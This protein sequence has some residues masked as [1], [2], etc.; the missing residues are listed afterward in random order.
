[1]PVG[2][3]DYISPEILCCSAQDFQVPNVKS[4]QKNSHYGP[5]CD[6]WSLGVVGY[7]LL[8]GVTPFA[9]DSL[10]E[11]Y[12]KIVNHEVKF[13][14]IYLCIIDLLNFFYFFF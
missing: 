6:F 5:E 1:M 12:N 2:T 3:P 4:S 9:S 14:S 8:Y 7:E 13:K 11:T 10:I